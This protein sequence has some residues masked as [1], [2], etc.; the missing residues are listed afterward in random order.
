MLK[1][2]L[3]SLREIQVG[4]GGAVQMRNMQ[5]VEVDDCEGEGASEQEQG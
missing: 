2:F 1:S 3:K 4:E 5:L